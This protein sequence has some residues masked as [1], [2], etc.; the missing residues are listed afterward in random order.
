[1]A[2]APVMTRTDVVAWSLAWTAQAGAHPTR[3]PPDPAEGDTPVRWFDPGPL[4]MTLEDR[5]G[6]AGYDDVRAHAAGLRARADAA[7]TSAEKAGI[8]ILTR[9][10]E[11]FPV[12]LA[13]IPDP[14]PVLWVRGDLRP[15]EHAVAIVGSRSATPHALGVARRLAE[16]LARVGVTVVSGLARGVDGEAH[17][18]A[19]L[20]HGRTV[21]IL[22]SGVDVIYPPEHVDLADRIAAHG[23]IVSELVPGTR[24]CGWHF[25]RRNRIISGLSAGVV[26]VEASTIS[27]SLITAGCALEQGRTVMA[28]PGGV[29]SGRN[30]GA[31]A[32]LRDGA[33]IVE[34]AQ[35]ILEE[36]HYVGAAA[37]MMAGAAGAHRDARTPAD[38]VLWAMKA[39][40]PYDVA[41]LSRQTGLDTVRLLSRLAELELGGWVERAGGGRFVRPGSNVLR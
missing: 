15:T 34:T 13:E 32:L 38:P 7:M 24:P 35:D 29:L 5:L 37:M 36:L 20:G 2:Q 31:H 3:R 9:L 26:V 25:P 12:T 4:E 40:E 27:G 41:F 33:R 14:P 18:G 17:Q 16:D 39:G 11:G 6:L 19:L 28:V 21:A 22:G 10:D 1:M 8:Q 30:R 23:A